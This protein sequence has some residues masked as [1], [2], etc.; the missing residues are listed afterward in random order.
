MQIFLS[1][2]IE[3]GKI[4]RSRSSVESCSKGVTDRAAFEYFL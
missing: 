4:N 2:L 1:D 3:M